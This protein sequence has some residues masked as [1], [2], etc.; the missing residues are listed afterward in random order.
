MAESDGRYT[1]S[2]FCELKKSFVVR[3]LDT[4]GESFEEAFPKV[5]EPIV[6]PVVLERLIVLGE[7]RIDILELLPCRNGAKS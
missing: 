1:H 5:E 3:V 7:E 2:K 6:L 4:R